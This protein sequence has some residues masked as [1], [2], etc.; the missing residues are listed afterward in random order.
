MFF[1]FTCGTH[2]F[3]S[4]LKGAEGLTVQ[5]QNCGNW[6]GRVMKRWEWFTFCFVPI[7]PF[8]LK[9]Y[10]EVGCHI[11]NFWQDIKYRPDVLQQM[12]GGAAAGGGGGGGGGQQGYNMAGGAA[13]HGGAGYGPP[14]AGVPQQYK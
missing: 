13:G 5:C 10:K 9:P 7:I 8:S 11:C 12:E 2:T 4:P 14:P 3:S 6:S 1:F